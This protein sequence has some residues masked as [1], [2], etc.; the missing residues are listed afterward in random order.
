MFFLCCLRFFLF[1]FSRLFMFKSGEEESTNSLFP[2][3]LTSSRI[4]LEKTFI[5]SSKMRF[6]VFFQFLIFWWF[7]NLKSPLPLLFRPLLAT[8]RHHR[9]LFPLSIVWRISSV[10]SRVKIMEKVELFYFKIMSHNVHPK[11][12]LK[13]PFTRNHSMRRPIMGSPLM[14]SPI[15]RSPFMRSPTMKFKKKWLKIFTKKMVNFKLQN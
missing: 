4:L 2:I 1:F 5:K 8:A 7:L 11:I 9:R 15:M 13:S 6:L 3:S 10:N 14:K 12:L